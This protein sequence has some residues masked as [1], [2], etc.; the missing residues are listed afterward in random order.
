MKN[1]IALIVFLIAAVLEVGG[2]ALIRKGMRGMGIGFIIV[3]FITLGCYGI[4]INT[5]NWDFSKLLGAY[6]AVFAVTS[7]LFGRFIFKETIPD[8]RWVG[9]VLVMIGGLII[10][11]WTT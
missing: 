7:A 1:P 4:I 8:A 6:I 11:F 2:D 3:G 10:Q 9:I 5:M